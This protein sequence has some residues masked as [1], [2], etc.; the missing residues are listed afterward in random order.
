[1]A[2]FGCT[3]FNVASG[4]Y[5]E[6]NEV[7]L[8]TSL[9]NISDK[10]AIMDGR[11][12]T[13]IIDTE[14]SYRVA[15][16]GF[17]GN[18]TLTVGAGRDYL[19]GGQSVYNLTVSGATGNQVT[20]GVGADYFW[21]WKHEFSWS[22]YWRQHHY[23]GR[24]TTTGEFLQGYATDVILDWHAGEDTLVVL[25]NGVAVIGGLRNGDGLVSLNAAN[26]IDLRDYAAI[27]TS[28]QDFDGA[29]GGDNL[30]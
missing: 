19:F 24:P 23:R 12:I 5:N 3:V 4:L 18:D 8:G 9:A 30:G 20:G 6:F 16:Y 10:S 14:W 7:Y 26:T 17:G 28:D 21:C 11:D 25:T 1:M 2:S 13:D 27:A 15:L 22:G 29:R